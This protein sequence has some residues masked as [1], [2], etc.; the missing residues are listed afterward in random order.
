[1]EDFLETSLKKIVILGAGKI[2]EV[3]YRCFSTDGGR[4][5]VA[6]S[7]EDEF[8]HGDVYLDLPVIRISELKKRFPPRSFDIF[9]AVGYQEINGLRARLFSHCHDLG[10]NFASYCSPS[11]W[12]YN[13][14]LVPKNFFLMASSVIQPGVVVADNVFIFSG[15][16]VGHHSKIGPHSWLASGAS[17]GGSV[18][19]ERQ[20][21]LGINAAVSHEIGI[22]ERS[23]IGAGALVTRDVGRNSVVIQKESDTIRLDIDRFLKL[24]KMG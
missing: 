2:A 3:A 17:M 5:V 15:V 20:C 9:I 7:V 12:V 1:M 13:G 22:G 6:F 14:F 11:A 21:F 16:M 4:E 23:F 24:T 10:Y 8:H 18:E 19:L